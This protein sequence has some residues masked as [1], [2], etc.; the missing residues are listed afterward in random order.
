MVAQPAPSLGQ[1]PTGW[2]QLLGPTRDGH[3]AGDVTGPWP[4]KLAATWDIEVGTG[5]ASPIVLGPQVFLFQRVDDSEGLWAYDLT[6]GKQRWKATWTS[7]FRAS[8]NNDDG[9][10]STPAITPSGLAI[11]FGAEGHAA[12]VDLRSGEIK[13]QRPLRKQINAPD[14]Y[15]GAGTSPLVFGDRVVICAGGK[16]SGAGVVCLDTESGETIWQ[17]TNYE[18]SYSSPVLVK[19]DQRDC[20]LAP[21]RLNTVLLDAQ[22][23]AVIGEVGFGS[24]GPTVNAASPITVGENKYWLTSNY[25][26]GTS[27]VKAKADALQTLTVKNRVLSSHYNTPVFAGSVLYGI[28]GYEGRGISLRAIDPDSYEVLWQKDNFSTAHL[29]ACGENLLALN[30]EGKLR[31]IAT[32]TTEYLEIAATQLAA[33]GQICR[34]APALLGQTLLV[35][36]SSENFSPTG[37]LLRVDLVPRKLK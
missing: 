28:D 21:M 5:F 27:V 8:I 1:A 33:P 15:F 37:H 25:G 29:L 16:R 20:I 23:G 4:S 18:S 14:G 3:A 17:A 9:P 22:T 13:W 6:T 36:T 32:S 7:N 10:R 35:R 2:P 34:A 12:A 11:C 24:R 19:L 31:A 26:I 30:L